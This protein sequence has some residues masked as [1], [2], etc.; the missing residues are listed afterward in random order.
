MCGFMKEYCICKRICSGTPIQTRVKKDIWQ[1]Q[2][3]RN[4][5]NICCKTGDDAWNNNSMC[6]NTLFYFMGLC[7]LILFHAI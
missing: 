2:H 1:C 3:Q 4:K 5:C 6:N 7:M